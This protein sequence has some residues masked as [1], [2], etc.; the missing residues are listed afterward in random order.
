MRS[1]PS[2]MTAPVHDSPCQRHRRYVAARRD[3]QVVSHVKGDRMLSL[4]AGVKLPT[5]VQAFH[6]KWQKFTHVAKDHHRLRI[7]IEHTAA[8]DP[9]RVC[10]RL[11]G[12]VPGR[13]QNVRIAVISLELIGR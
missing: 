11:Y 12:P 8:H 3:E 1:A 5:L 7:G 4:V 2:D 13:T 6:G 10:R 9:K